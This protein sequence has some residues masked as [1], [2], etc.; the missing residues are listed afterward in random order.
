LLIAPFNITVRR[1]RMALLLCVLLLAGC[2]KKTAA[3]VRGA[4]TNSASSA[5]QSD[6][7]QTLDRLTQTVRKYA[8]ENR[9]APKSLNELVAAGYLSEVPE[10]PPGKKFVIDQNLRVQLQ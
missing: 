4:A 8:A 3:P 7:T 2:G 1:M 6:A 5:P 10:P 9:A